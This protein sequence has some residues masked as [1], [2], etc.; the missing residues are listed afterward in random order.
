MNRKIGMGSSVINGAMVAGFA[1]AMAVGALFWSYLTSALIAFS[2]V[3]MACSFA[4]LATPERRT[5]ALCGM[6]FA[7]MY[8]AIN[9]G[10][11]F[12]QMTT[13][14]LSSLTQQAAELLDFRHYGL[15]FSLDMLGYT[16]MSLATLFM[17]LSL[18]PRTRAERW[19]RGLLMVH[20]VFAVS[21]FLMPLLGVFQADLG[22]D[23]IGTV[24]LMFWCA[25]FLPI[26]VL[27]VGYFRK[28]A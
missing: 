5:A 12:T 22:M 11:Y 19:L 26:G 13:V 17:G 27:S 25:Y 2:F 28:R 20:G 7:A 8:A 10:V 16:L 21:C 14:R 23:W 6:A 9:L 24:V 18:A 4:A 1:L 15:A 3:G